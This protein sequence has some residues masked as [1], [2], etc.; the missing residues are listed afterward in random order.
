[1]SNAP[2]SDR[3]LQTVRVADFTPGIVRFGRGS[4]AQTYAPHA[5]P[6][7]AAQAFRCIAEP[8]I[9]LVPFP[10]YVPAMTFTA[11]SH[12][13][14]QALSVGNQM[15]LPSTIGDSLVTAYI[16]HSSAGTAY[17]TRGEVPAPTTAAPVTPTTLYSNATAGGGVV[18]WNS[19]DVGFFQ[20]P[21]TSVYK[22]AVIMTDPSQYSYITVPDWHN[23]AGG[24]A[25]APFATG[26]LP[27]PSAATPRIFYHAARAGVFHYYNAPNDTAGFPAPGADQLDVSD[28][29]SLANF[30]LSGF[31]YP[32]MGS[33]IG[34][35]GSISTGE[36][37]MCYS[38]G[39]AVLLYGDL[40]AP[41]SA[42]KL[43]G[44][45]G[46]GA[47]LGRAALSPAGLIY[48]TSTDGAYAWNGN[49]NSQKIS[50]QIP[51][52][53]LFRT[54]LPD[55]YNSE[56]ARR[57]SSN[58]AWGAW[59]MFPNN[60][61][62]DSIGGGWWQSEDPAVANFQVNCQA[63]SDNRYFYA[64]PG[65]TLAAAGVSPAVTTYQYDRYS[66]ASSYMWLSNPVVVAADA[67]VSLQLL[68][69]VV[70]NPSPA[71]CTVTLTP[72]VPAG[73]VPFSQQN[74]GQAAVFTVP[75]ATVAWRG[76]QRVGYS[77][78]N[79]QVRVDAA[80][81]NPA[82]PAPTV[83]EFAVGYTTTRVAGVQ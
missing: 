82:L 63:V 52:D 18:P 47:C 33:S 13:F 7:S 19:M 5:P 26:A 66:P 53:V 78:Y 61:V 22:R 39:G 36:F 77:D 59:V 51:D 40:Y 58:L 54:P 79:V 64:T 1:M 24:G 3:N 41:T 31:Y 17:V 73:Q 45:V 14:A 71:P 28:L 27:V 67:L 50:T 23:P 43:P 34:T 4:L 16:T 57:H 15:A 25:A 76:S 37:F 69:V 81:S 72:A 12:T 35:W 10:D 30:H 11:G 20:D 44:V 56:G 70:S 2:F 48:A 6:G 9:G 74:Q 38:A 42:Y 62:F 21:S 32:E 60:W 55:P 65:F 68:E 46:P 83:H 8:G 80:N 75:A 49:N 29:L